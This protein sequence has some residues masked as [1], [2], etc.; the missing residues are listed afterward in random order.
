MKLSTAHKTGWGLVAIMAAVVLCTLPFW[1]TT[2]AVISIYI[3]SPVLGSREEGFIRELRK[4]GYRVQIN[5]GKKA[6]PALAAIWFK[7]PEAVSGLNTGK[8][9]YNFIYNEA[10]YPFDWR[11]LHNIPIVLTPYRDLYEHYTRSNIKSAWFTLGVNTAEFAFPD[12]IA[13][14]YSLVWYGDNNKNTPLA[15][16]M[17]SRPDIRFLGKFWPQDDKTIAAVGDKEKGHV[18]AQT[19]VAVVYS[20][21][22]T[23]DTKKIPS[24]VAEAAASGAL[25][26]TSENAAVREIYGD[27]VIMVQNEEDIPLLVDYYLAHP[28][29]IATK[30]IAARSITAKKLSSAATATRF[31]E[32]L[33]WLQNNEN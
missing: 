5:P 1:A 15:D 9:V 19:A 20:P 33:N 32:I 12:E 11:G 17:R 14:K 22:G 4:K 28:E 3:D 21:A 27:N 2:K 7:P 8:A 6:H 23:S 10:Y 18:L 29:I 13:K 25:V 26:I 31:A 16:A 30:T 24:G